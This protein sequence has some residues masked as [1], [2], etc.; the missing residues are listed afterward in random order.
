MISSVTVHGTRRLADPRSSSILAP[1]SARV[2]D[3]II[4][5]EHHVLV[6][7]YVPPTPVSDYGSGKCLQSRRVSTVMVCSTALIH[8]HVHIHDE[9]SNHEFMHHAYEVPKTLANPRWYGR[10]LRLRGRVVI[11]NVTDPF[12]CGT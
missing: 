3:I 4:H 1:G 6:G 2:F 11:A 10:Y 12:A 5:F 8:T 9:K 7:G